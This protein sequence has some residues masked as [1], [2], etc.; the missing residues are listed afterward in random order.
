MAA[1]QSAE[2]LISSIS[3][4]CTFERL[5][6]LIFL[7][8]F[9]LRFTALDLR[10]FHQ[11]EAVHA[12][13]AYNLLTQGNYVYD[14]VYHGPFLYYVTAGMFALFGDSDVIARIIPALCGLLL[15]PLVYGI[16][17]LGYLDK[18][19]TLVAALFLA[20]SPEMVYF[21]RFLRNDI[22]IV[23][24][25]LLFLVALLWYFKKKSWEYAVF[26]GLAAGLGMC[27]KENM[28]IVL[29]IFGVYVLYLLWSRKL[30]LPL[31]WKKHFVLGAAVAIT[32]MALFYSSFGMHPEVLAHGW[33]D[34]IVHWTSMH[35][36]QRIGGPPYTYLLLLALY[37]LPI[38][39]LAVYGC[40]QFVRPR[41]FSRR[42]SGAEAPDD[43]ISDLSAKDDVASFSAKSVSSL[44]VH[45]LNS[46][47]PNQMPAPAPVQN[48][49]WKKAGNILK[50]PDAPITFDKKR[51]FMR[52]CIWWFLLSLLAYAYI[53]EKVP[54]LAL[55]QLLP[56]IFVAVYHM[57]DRKAVIAVIVSLLLIVTTVSLVFVPGDINEPIVQVQHSAD[58]R[59]VTE[60]I[61]G[62]GSVAIVTDTYW[63]LPWYLRDTDATVKYYNKNADLSYLQNYDAGVLV[64]HD[65][66]SPDT[67]EGFTRHEMKQA[68]WFSVYEQMNRLAPY[69]FFRDG[70]VGSLNWA[71][72]VK[73][74]RTVV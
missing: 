3:K 68:Y 50:R 46:E 24:F 49:I 36:A 48:P 12:W 45:D 58:V 34:A 14:P 22:F 35:E 62:T 18:K 2:D 29:A 5:F 57:T 60:W 19:Q 39:I 61:E 30:T 28:P 55:H 16:F 65:L 67:I 38:L 40:W 42:T 32:L 8:A 9:I 13:F 25:T 54:W 23:F 52:F 51:E 41:S 73:D 21:S 33:I 27:A 26:A 37:D 6:V 59:A 31:A 1:S 69:Y 20:I 4:H 66:E 64:Y 63:P 15:L 10:I 70:P 74:A 17:R 43:E 47:N 71:V 44:S 7:I 53:G 11:D 72:F 56:M